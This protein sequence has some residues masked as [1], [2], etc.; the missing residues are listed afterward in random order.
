MGLLALNQATVSRILVHIELKVA[1]ASS[2]LST[3]SNPKSEEAKASQNVAAEVQL[4]IWIKRQ[5]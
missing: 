4:K 2:I 1:V 3:E 5:V